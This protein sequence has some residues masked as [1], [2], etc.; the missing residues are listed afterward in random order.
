MSTQK[1]EYQVIKI[2]TQARIHGKSDGRLIS[3]RFLRIV[4][5]C[6][7]SEPID[8]ISSKSEN[9]SCS[10]AQSRKFTFG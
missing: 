10:K 4:Y 2:S 9:E 6:Q 8:I 7:N 3:H 1:A 5:E